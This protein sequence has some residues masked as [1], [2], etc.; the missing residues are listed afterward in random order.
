MYSYFL[1]LLYYHFL[2]YTSLDDIFWYITGFLKITLVLYI[3]LSFL[4]VLI[5]ETDTFLNLPRRER[6][7]EYWSWISPLHCT[8]SAELIHTSLEHFLRVLRKV[9]LLDKLSRKLYSNYCYFLDISFTLDAN[10]DLRAKL[11]LWYD[12]LRS[13]NVFLNVTWKHERWNNDALS[14]FCIF[15]HKLTFHYFYK[16]FIVA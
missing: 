8:Y 2:W 14:F 12:L 10:F 9:L 7:G 13:Y 3:N 16:V 1:F 6:V 5:I 15:N 4:H 11:A